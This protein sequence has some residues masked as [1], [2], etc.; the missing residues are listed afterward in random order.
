MHKR[1]HDR[2]TILV[3]DDSDA[4]AFAIQSAVPEC[5]VLHAPDGI[6]ALDILR[7]WHRKTDLIILDLVMPRMDGPTTCMLIRELASNVPILPFTGFPNDKAM[8]PLHELGCLPPLLKPVDP[9][10]LAET[11]RAAL[12]TTPPPLA[13]GY[14]VLTWAQE[15]AARQ[16]YAGRTKPLLHVI[17]CAATGVIQRGLQDL[18]EHAGARVVARTPYPKNI[19]DLLDGT[20]D[21][22]AVVT[23]C[24]ELP[25]L[26]PMVG[27]HQ[28]P[29]VC[30]VATLA[31]GLTALE[32]I[33]DKNS[34]LGIVVEHVDERQ[35]T[36]RMDQAL[37]QVLRGES[38]IPVSLREP[39]AALHL[40][41]QEQILL[42]AEVRELASSVIAERL[43]IDQ[44]ALR[45][46]RKRLREKLDVPSEQSLGEWA[47]ARWADTLS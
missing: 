29:I 2:P 28:L 8:A 3:I 1:N 10:V 19:P 33:A 11:I 24:A 47:E 6:A 5:E 46:R 42:A 4:I 37:H 17:I 26:L 32:W 9:I 43:G 7:K 30:V 40:S 12:G 44:P 45:Q 22:V 41:D 34:R 25:R 23:T 13:P 20:P 38:A 31:D 14:G 18:V 15:Q 16:E 27:S 39:F 36:V 35:T 21:I